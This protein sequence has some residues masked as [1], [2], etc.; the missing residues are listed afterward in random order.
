[1]GKTGKEVTMLVP[2]SKYFNEGGSEGIEVIRLPPIC[3]CCNDG[4]NKGK[5]V[6]LLKLKIVNETS[7]EGKE[8]NDCILNPYPLTEHSKV[9]RLSGKLGNESMPIL[10]CLCI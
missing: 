10:K 8:G 6:T 2:I 4:G 9:T 3:K 7:L 5:V 1:M